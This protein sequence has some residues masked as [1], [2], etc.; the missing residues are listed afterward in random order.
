MALSRKK[1]NSIIIIASLLM[2]GTLSLLD[3][4][5]QSLPEDVLPLFNDDT[6]LAQ[7]QLQQDN[8]TLWLRQLNGQWQC[9][10]TVLNCDQWASAW[11][12]IKVSLLES[13]EEIN[14]QSISITIKTTNNNQALQWQYYPKMGLLQ[15]SANNWYHIPPSLRSH[16]LPVVDANIQ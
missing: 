11:Q 12:Q 2:I 3:N 6:P 1:W 5:T 16:L 15:S 8:R 4:Q 9:E 10:T 14:D 13:V 7:L